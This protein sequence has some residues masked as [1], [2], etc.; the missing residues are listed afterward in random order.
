[1]KKILVTLVLSAAFMTSA[2][3]S[4]L[5][6]YEVKITNAT[7]HHV[8][9]PPLV[10]S[11]NTAFSVFSVGG[12]ASDGLVTQAETGNPGPLSLEVS[13]AV[14]VRDVVAGDGVIL[15]GQSASLRITARKRDRLSLTSM[16][17][18][19]NDAFAGL[20][21]VALPKRSVQYFAYAYDAGSEMNNE[22]CSH[23][24]GPPCAPDSGNDRTASGE[25]FIAIHNGVHGIG[26][27]DASHLDWRG[28]VAIITITRVDD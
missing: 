17:A 2:Q 19:T 1:M 24:P 10:I 13:N 21:S 28:P 14:G 7:S 25:G 6:T 9:T 15:Y 5:R 12:T 4:G 23:I 27:L 22:N 18:T 20:N 11:H 26:D 16:L 8:L 3:A